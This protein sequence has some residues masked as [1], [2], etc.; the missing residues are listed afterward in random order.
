MSHRSR[1][2]ELWGHAMTDQK[3]NVAEIVAAAVESLLEVDA[4]AYAVAFAAIGA[5][6]ANGY[7]IVEIDQS[8]LRRV[9]AEM[10]LEGE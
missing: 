2:I 7:A 1:L 9:L 8:V 6:T 3:Y 5:L 4:D 10:H